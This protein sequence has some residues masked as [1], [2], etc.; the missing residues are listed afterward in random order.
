MTPRD[1]NGTWV[2]ITTPYLDRHTDA[3]Q[4]YAR[5]EN[6]GYVP[7]D[8]GYTIHDLEASGCHPER[9]VQAINRPSRDTAESFMPKW[10]DTRE[11]RASDSRAYG[12]RMP[13]VRFGCVQKLLDK[14]CPVEH[15]GPT[16]CGVSSI[17]SA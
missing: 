5:Q 16:R 11:V 9:I 17:A 10:S 7:A 14:A 12:R 3:L 13:V 8:D 6:C 2:E 1:L 4:T 15:S